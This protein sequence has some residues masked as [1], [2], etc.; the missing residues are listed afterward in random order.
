MTDQNITDVVRDKYG[1]AARQVMSGKASCCGETSAS[2][3]SGDPITS[4]NGHGL[5]PRSE[6]LNPVAET[7]WPR[8]E[9]PVPA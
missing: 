4:T 3:L 8:P 6:R 2:G 9:I 7:R 5:D 1:K